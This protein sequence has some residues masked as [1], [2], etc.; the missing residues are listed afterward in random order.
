MVSINTYITNIFT[1]K[2]ISFADVK[3]IALCL[4]IDPDL[5]ILKKH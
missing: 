5:R 1:T 2:S 4:Q 3:K